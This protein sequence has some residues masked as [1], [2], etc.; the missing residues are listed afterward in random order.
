MKKFIIAAL[1]CVNL[2]LVGVLVF[3]AAPAWAQA[4]RGQANYL[5]VAGQVTAGEQA[6]YVIDTNRRVLGTFRLDTTRPEWRWK[7]LP[8]RDL[9]RDF[10][11]GPR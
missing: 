4:R 10:P 6:L 9:S 8:P 11:L 2:V 7:P 3:H 1:I 5:L